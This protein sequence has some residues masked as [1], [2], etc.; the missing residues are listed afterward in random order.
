M[1]DVDERDIAVATAVFITVNSG[2]LA[3]GPIIAGSLAEVMSLRAV[4]AL[5]SLGPLVS[6]VGAVLLGD[7]A[8]RPPVGE[9]PAARAA[10][11]R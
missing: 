5:A 1:R 3:L 7:A 11:A 9:P 10:E 6:T 2:A 8:A 4:L